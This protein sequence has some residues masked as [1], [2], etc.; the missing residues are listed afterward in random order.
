M[1]AQKSAPIESWRCSTAIRDVPGRPGTV[2]NHAQDP[3]SSMPTDPRMVRWSDH[4]LVKAELL[5]LARADV[6]QIVLVGHSRRVRNAGAAG[7]LTEGG[8]VV[9]AYNHPDGR[10]ELT[11]FVVSVWRR[12][13]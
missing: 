4:A 8:R 11:A 12:R 7:W 13:A 6:E 5:G 10:D 9:V 3:Q 2:R 1:P